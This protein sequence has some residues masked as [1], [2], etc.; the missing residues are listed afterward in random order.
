MKTCLI[1]GHNGLDLDVTLNLRSFYKRLG[2]KVFFSE[3]LYDADLLVVLR[4]VDNEIDISS[5]GYS[6]V[7]VYDYGGWDYDAF[8]NTIDHAITYIFCT[9]EVKRAR[10]IEQLHFPKEHVFIAL[11]PVNV[12][13]WSKKIEE[14]R[15]KMVHIGNFKPISNDDPIKQLFN[16]AI[17]HFKTNVWGMGWNIDKKF[18]HGKTGLFSVSSIYAKSKFAFG[19]MY[20]FQREVT[21]SGRFWQ[22]PLNGCS[23]FSEVGLYT[24]TIPGVI[25]TDYSIGDLEKKLNHEVDRISIQKEAKEFWINQYKKT[26]SLVEPTCLILKDRGFNI[27]NF[28]VYTSL[29]VNNFLRVAYQRWSVFKIIK[30]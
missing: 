18:Y 3:K 7:H 28:L 16:E 14:V 10:L 30:K 4:A 20:P 5:F 15:Y 1:Y 13:L 17:I 22:A 6:L 26:L 19:L 9:S 12:H 8:V 21:F 29:S 2:F 24:S 11:P 25:E 23:V 27:N